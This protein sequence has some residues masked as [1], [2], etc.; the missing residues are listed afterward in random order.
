M[1]TKKVNLPINLTKKEVPLYKEKST[2]VLRTLKILILHD[3]FVSN[4]GLCLTEKGLIKE[5]H[6]NY[7]GS[8]DE[9]L[10]HAMVYYLKA[11]EDD[12]HLIT[13]GNSTTYLLAHH[14]WHNFYHWICEVIPRIWK[15]RDRIKHMVLLLPEQAKKEDWALSSL[16][17]FNFKDIY[18]ISVAKSLMVRNLCLPEL[19]PEV[20]SYYSKTL[21]EL[22]KF[23]LTYLQKNSLQNIDFGEKI[24]LSRKK[25]F[26]RKVENEDLVQEIVKKHG[27]RVLY[28]EDFNF[29]EQLSIYSKAKYLISIHGAG[30]T[31]IIWMKERSVIFELHRE[32]T[33]MDDTHNLIYW[34]L[35]D[36]LGHKYL[37]QV[38]KP[39][40][41]KIGYM[42]ADLIVDIET[43]KNNLD[44]ISHL[45]K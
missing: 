24:Y 11:N 29:F 38:C 5:C 1:Y 43:F 16:E 42:T 21:R 45:A 25:A 13:I 34:Y 2:Y 23:Y 41:P 28:N 17:P 10:H 35:A 9:F 27:F 31:N 33:S 39:T 26:K 14:P 3:V 6:H 40:D 19:K 22:K 18:Y 37:R 7:P 8:R 30:L 20:N 44:L 36:S 32:I 4:T 12:N 15:V